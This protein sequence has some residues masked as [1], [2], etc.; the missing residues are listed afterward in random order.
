MIMQS[1]TRKIDNYRS[2]Q[3]GIGVLRNK[4]EKKCL[5]L[6]NTHFKCARATILDKK[7]SNL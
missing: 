6:R 2:H 5:L 3:F 4:K 7:N 1:G